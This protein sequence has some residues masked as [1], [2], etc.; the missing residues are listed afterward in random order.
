MLGVIGMVAFATAWS[1]I[2]WEDR[3]VHPDLRA[4]GVFMVGS[5]VSVSTAISG[6]LVGI[7][8][9]LKDKERRLWPILGTAVSSAVLLAWL[10]LRI[11]LAQ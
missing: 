8:G 6:L 2:L 7:V 5:L 10:C 3:N 1:W 9:L 11:W 4:F